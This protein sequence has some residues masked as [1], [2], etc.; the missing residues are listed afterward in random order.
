MLVSKTLK[1]TPIASAEVNDHSLSLS[2]SFSRQGLC[3]QKVSVKVSVTKV[4]VTKN[5]MF[6]L[7][8]SEMLSDKFSRESKRLLWILVF[9]HAHRMSSLRAD[10]SKVMAHQYS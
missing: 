5:E 4:S 7:C 9:A 6:K 3:H 2:F 1:G 8:N 10:R